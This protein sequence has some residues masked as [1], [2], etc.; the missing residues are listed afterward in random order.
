MVINQN[1]SLL[2]QKTQVKEGKYKILRKKDRGK[3]L[4]QSDWLFK[5][6]KSVC[7]CTTINILSDK[8][9]DQ[10]MKLRGRLRTECR[11]EIFTIKDITVTVRPV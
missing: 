4:N 2:G 9:K 5:T 3:E 10:L 6:N 7:S 11:P 1:M 8:Y